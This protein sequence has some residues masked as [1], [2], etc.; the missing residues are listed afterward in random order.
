VEKTIYR[1]PDAE[2]EVMQAVWDCTPPVSRADIERILEDKHRRLAP[3]TILTLL[4]RLVERGALVISK[5]GRSNLYT[6][7]ISRRDY[8]AS[9]SNR[10]LNKLCGGDIHILASALCGSGLSREEVAEL[11]RLLDEGKL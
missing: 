6:P 5:Q 11:R 8:L 1:L 9:Q 3:T 4:S 10:F 7:V 2:L